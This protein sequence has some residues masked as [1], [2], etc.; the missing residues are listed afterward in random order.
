[1]SLLT[2]HHG[3]REM[4]LH[5][6]HSKRDIHMYVY[7]ATSRCTSGIFLHGPNPLYPAADSASIPLR[8]NLAEPII[9]RM[10]KLSIYRIDYYL[11]HYC[12]RFAAQVEQA[13]A[14]LSRWHGAAAQSNRSKL[15][16]TANAYGLAM[17]CPK[18]LAAYGD[19]YRTASV[20]RAWLSAPRAVR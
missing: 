14:K 11:L 9:C 17:L 13:R 8:C 15:R 4:R 10:P 2:L 20:L 5:G 16:C 6:G 19:R 18:T 12:C 3:V 1:M 7:K